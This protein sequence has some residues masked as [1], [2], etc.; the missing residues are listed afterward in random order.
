MDV[1]EGA[2][3]HGD[4]LLEEEGGTTGG[5]PQS[6]MS[7]STVQ[8]IATAS[9]VPDMSVEEGKAMSKSQRR[10]SRIVIAVACAA[11]AMA[12]ASM[13]LEG[14]AIAIIAFVIPLITGPYVI[15]QRKMLNKLPTM[16]FVINQTRHQVNRL[17]VQNSRF[18]KENDRLAVEVGELKQLDHQFYKICQESGTNVE[19]MKKLVQE[20]GEIQKQMKVCSI[21]AIRDI[22]KSRHSHILMFV[23]HIW[24]LVPNRL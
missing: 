23:T 17:T 9:E 1:E 3:S 20:N 10:W 11:M 2:A 4:P 16:V 19:D 7:N 13:A 12:I 15:Y 6:A 24:R 21:D 8:A 14:S 18:T 5:A 22:A